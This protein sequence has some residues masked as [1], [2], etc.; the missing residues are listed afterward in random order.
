MMWCR[1][2]PGGS[3]AGVDVVVV[4]VVVVVADGVGVGGAGLVPRQMHQRQKAK[5]SGSLFVLSC[6]LV[7]VDAAT[8]KLLVL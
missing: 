5:V 2:H 3:A 7:T 6:L 8:Q 4:V 1:T